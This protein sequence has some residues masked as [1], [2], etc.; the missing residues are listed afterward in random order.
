MFVYLV[1]NLVNG[2]MYVGKTTLTIEERWRYHLQNAR[3]GLP[4]HLY[5]AIRKYRPDS[6]IVEALVEADNEETLNTLERL[7]IISLG[8]H[9]TT[10]GYNMTF[11][12]D[13][14]APTEEVRRKMRAKALGR[15]TSARQKEVT[16]G[17]FKG[18]P[19]SVAQRQ[20]MAA[21][22]DSDRREEQA[23][24]ARRVNATENKK[25]KDYTCPDCKQEFRQVTKGVY[26]GHRKACL[27]WQRVEKWLEEE[28]EKF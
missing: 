21:H 7:W 26:G 5:R 14:G 3:A 1:T 15:P 8:T 23:E 10:F 25:L 2:K 4:Y 13:G 27:Y 9:S 17:L 18:K 16:R 20:K 19:K 6:F 11:G 24:V 22:W 28:E 12:G